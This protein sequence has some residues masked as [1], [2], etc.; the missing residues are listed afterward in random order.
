MEFWL[1]SYPRSGNSYFRILL[2]NRYDIPSIDQ[3]CP[4]ELETA[5]LRGT[6][7]VRAH[8]CDPN[9]APAIMGLKTHKPPE[10]GDTRPGVYIVRDGRD[11]LVSYAHFAL[12]FVYK[13]ASEVVTPEILRNTIRDLILEPNSPYWTWSRNVDAWTNRKNTVVIQFEDLITNPGKAADRAVAGMGLG[14]PI[15]SKEIPTFKE[16]K[17][18]DPQFFRKG[19]K[20]EWQEVFTA[21]L[22]DLFWQHNGATM[23]RFGY[24]H[25]PPLRPA[26]PT[27]AAA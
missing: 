21:D 22:Y 26:V 13:N 16:L 11:A 12:S 14:V 9:A 8:Y 6:R 27:P 4:E 7:F 20:G 1:A 19:Q 3:E 15:V 17:T 2:R 5:T 18:V 25:M 10:P 23:T 24:A